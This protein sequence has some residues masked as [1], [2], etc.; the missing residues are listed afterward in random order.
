[1]L[2]HHRN[3][4]NSLLFIKS[5]FTKSG[6]NCI[7]TSIFSNNGNTYF[8]NM[9]KVENIE[10]ADLHKPALNKIMSTQE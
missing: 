3:F 10:N 1:M 2:L 5:V 7:A 8:R 9:Q 4:I 6:K